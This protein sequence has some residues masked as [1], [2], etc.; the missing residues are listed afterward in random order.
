MAT[1]VVRADF[2]GTKNG[3]DYTREFRSSKGSIWDAWTE[4]LVSVHEVIKKYGWRVTYYW[5][6]ENIF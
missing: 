5:V 1:L 4:I 6:L 3:L 2:K